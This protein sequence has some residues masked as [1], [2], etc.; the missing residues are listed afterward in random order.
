MTRLW[1]WLIVLSFLGGLHMTTPAAADDNAQL[2]K[3]I[4]DLLRQTEQIWD[5][6]DYAKLKELWDG[7]DPM[8]IYMP[9]EVENPV[10]GWEKLEKYWNPRPG[11]KFLEGIRNRY[12]NVQ[13]KYLAPDLAVATY[14][15]RYE[16]Q[17]V[18]QKPTAGWDRMMAV[19]RKKP[20]GWRYV[21]YVEAPLNP[22]TQMRRMS[23]EA[24]SDDFADF[25]A[26]HNKNSGDEE[27]GKMRNWGEQFD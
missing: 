12:S 3:E 4:E 1:V 15:L 26:E 24:V 8:P 21:A 14:E 17:V 10:I 6:G 16:M 23:R 20:D 11:V 7:D 9:E 22:I 18:G 25:V 27:K 2:V 13:A 19:F 5:E